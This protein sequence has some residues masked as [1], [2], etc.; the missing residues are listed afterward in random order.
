MN[1]MKC[2]YC[3]KSFEIPEVATFNTETY[4]G[5]GHNLQCTKCKNI[6]Y[7]SMSRQVKIEGIET[8]DATEDDWGNE[9]GK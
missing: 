9:R 6:A 3:N 8:S 7:V 5:G 1:E 2:P 4:G